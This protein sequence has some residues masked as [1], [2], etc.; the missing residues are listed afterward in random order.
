MTNWTKEPPKEPGWYVTAHRCLMCTT[1]PNHWV[2]DT[3]RLQAGETT[4]D[5]LWRSV[6]PIQPPPTEQETSDAV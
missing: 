6:D 4:S 1:N 5:R 3:R 2:F